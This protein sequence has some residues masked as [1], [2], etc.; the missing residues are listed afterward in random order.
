MQTLL[1]IGYGNSISE[2]L[3]SLSGLSKGTYR[4]IKLLCEF[5]VHIPDR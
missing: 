5:I 4:K 2:I 3:S 1:Y